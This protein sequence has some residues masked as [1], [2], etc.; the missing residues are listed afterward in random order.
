MASETLA[1]DA[2]VA[3]KWFSRKDEKCLRRALDIRDAHV[4]GIVEAQVPDLLYYEVAN[5]LV[6][7]A[8]FS[9]EMA[10][11]AASALFAL[12]LSTVPIG[13]SLLDVAVDLSHRNSITVYDACHLAVAMS[14]RCPLVTANP[15]HQGKE[16]GCEVVALSDWLA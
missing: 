6:T 1:V 10:R 14:R 16:I 7:K 12:S 3:V 8:R 5:A 4:A 2:S 13:A 11:S 15:K 9:R